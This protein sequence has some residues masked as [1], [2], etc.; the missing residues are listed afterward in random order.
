MYRIIVVCT[1][2]IC[3]SPMAEGL[4]Q[5]RMPLDLKGRVEVSSAGTY[6]V[7]GHP[8]S[9]NAV[10]AM[11]LMGIDFT[12]HRARQLTRL[13]LEEAD[14]VLAMEKYH[15]KEIKR[16]SIKSTPDVRLIGAFGLPP[17][18]Q[19]IDDP[20]GTP[21]S[22]YKSCIQRLIPC[23]DGLIEWLGQHLPLEDG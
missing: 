18:Q 21:L 15:L 23:V 19:E 7:Q 2:N 12:R 8:A 3:R 10:K 14:L 16:L 1:G 20:Y 22:V 17:G 11:A 9:D 5:N 13:M 4:I 6:G